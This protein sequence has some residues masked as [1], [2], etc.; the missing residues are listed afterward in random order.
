MVLILDRQGTYIYLLYLAVAIN[1][2]DVNVAFYG[3]ISIRDYKWPRK[4]KKYSNCQFCKLYLE[5]SMDDVISGQTIYFDIRQKR[6]QS[7]NV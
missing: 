1:F 2:E 3:V 7:K 6:I 4:M 5:V